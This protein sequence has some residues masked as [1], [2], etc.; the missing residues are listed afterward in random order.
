MSST[1]SGSGISSPI[2]GRPRSTSARPTSSAN[3]GLPCV[4]SA[5]RRISGRGSAQPEPLRQQPPRGVEIERTDLEALAPD[6]CSSGGRRPGRRASR[7]ATGSS[8]AAAR[9]RPAPRRRRVEPLQVVDRHQQ[10]ARGSARSSLSTPSA[11]A[12][13]ARRRVVRLGAQQR[14][15]ERG[16]LR[17]RQAGEVDAVEEV[18]QRRERVARPRP[19]PRHDDLRP[20]SRAASIPASHSAVLPIP[21]SPV[22]TSARGDEAAA[23]NSRSRASS[24]SRATS[25]PSTGAASQF[26]AE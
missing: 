11:I 7:N 14:H 17:P 24:V 10:P 4:V 12:C 9:R 26:A 20:R 16:P 5:T 2:S 23:R 22:S 18:D 6:A 21:G 1:A 25:G 8:P 15:L 19:R 13:G 3:S